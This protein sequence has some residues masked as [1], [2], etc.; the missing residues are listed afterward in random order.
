MI[1]EIEIKKH[2]Q[3]E[4]TKINLTENLNLIIGESGSGK[5]LLAEVVAF[6]MGYKLTSETKKQ[7]EIDIEGIVQISGVNHK[8]RRHFRHNEIIHYLDEKIVDFDFY[9]N[10]LG[11]FIKYYDQKFIYNNGVTSKYIVNLVN[12]SNHNLFSKH[13]GQF[14]KYSRIYNKY[15]EYKKE[16]EEL[17]S[18][19]K[20]KS[21][22]NELS[23]YDLSEIK[24]V[25]DEYE[26]FEHII[27][28]KDRYSQI[29][30]DL[31]EYEEIFLKIGSNFAKSNF[32]EI[33]NIVEMYNS[34]IIE[35]QDNLVEIKKTKN[36][37]SYRLENFSNHNEMI[38]VKNKL[39]RIYSCD[40]DELINLKKDSE[41]KIVRIEE[42]KIDL[43][44]I[45]SALKQV[46][47]KFDELDEELN[48]HIIEE[49]FEV[50]DN[51]TK[52]LV[53]LGFNCTNTKLIAKKK[54]L[55]NYR[56]N[57]EGNYL[58]EI[59]IQDDN[60]L[61]SVNQLSGGEMSRLIIALSLQMI[62]DKSGNILIYDEIDTGISGEFSVKIGREFNNASKNNQ[63]I[64]VSH[65]PQVC[66]KADRLIKVRKNSSTTPSTI[67]EV[68]NESIE[69]EIAK[70]ILGNIYDKNG[71]EV[72][73]QLINK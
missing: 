19:H 13:C 60:K 55:T 52:T 61:K 69:M 20:L 5:S 56:R 34:F 62:K 59:L 71:I 39:C 12:V 70:M 35:Y 64:A 57:I 27:N 58:Y 73:K 25:T 72:A 17:E 1:K 26:S 7:G 47:L 14:E 11:D 33:S 68:G 8:I 38:S 44:N 40:L 22:N 53:E 2:F 30:D 4:S 28:K 41:E 46:V 54:R 37:L 6:L 31:R 49:S 32:E 10:F 65:N 3:I 16:L 29:Y 66:A 63:L 24:R 23:K 48:N 18:D 45:E 50:L 43:Q 51:V 67:E 36:D 21:I 9:S 15:V 42:L